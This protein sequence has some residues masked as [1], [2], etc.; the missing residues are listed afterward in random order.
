MT[1]T[2]ATTERAAEVWAMLVRTPSIVNTVAGIEPIPP[3]IGLDFVQDVCGNRD[4]AVSAILE[5]ASEWLAVRLPGNGEDVSW[6]EGGWVCLHIKAEHLSLAET[7][8]SHVAERCETAERF[9]L[10][11]MYDA[12]YKGITEARA[13]NVWSAV[14]TRTLAICRA[15]CAAAYPE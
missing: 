7:F 11:A 1:E 14:A 10:I 4:D 8:L 9:Y 13:W 15:V 3:A 6:A 2:N 5:A 12:D